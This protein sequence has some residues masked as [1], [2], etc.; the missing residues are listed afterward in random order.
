PYWMIGL[1]TTGSISLGCA[2]VAGRKRVPSPAAGNT[3]LRIAVT[4]LLYLFFFFARSRRESWIRLTPEL[5]TTIF[6]GLALRSRARMRAASRGDNPSSIVMFAIRPRSAGD[7]RRCAHTCSEA[8]SPR[9][10]LGTI[11]STGPPNEWCHRGWRPPSRSRTAPPTLAPRHRNSR[12]D[13]RNPPPD[14]RAV[15]T[16]SAGF[17]AFP[18]SLEPARAPRVPRDGRYAGRGRNRAHHRRRPGRPSQHLAQ[19]S[20]R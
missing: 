12:R 5:S 19:P 13:R 14:G 7:R 10:A 2:L 3:A 1:S 15:F 6:G 20:A 18:S 8:C 4:Y 9:R 17:D 11:P 16:G